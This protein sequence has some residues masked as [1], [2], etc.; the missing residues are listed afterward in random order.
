MSVILDGGA[1]LNTNLVGL[2]K[3]LAEVLLPVFHHTATNNE[4]RHDKEALYDEDVT[5][6]RRDREGRH[7]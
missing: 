5:I 4:A 7:D 1:A 3:L 2:L 6:F